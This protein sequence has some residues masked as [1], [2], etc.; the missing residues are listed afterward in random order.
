MLR[1]RQPPPVRAGWVWRAKGTGMKLTRWVMAALLLGATAGTSLATDDA[2]RTPAEVPPGAASG[3]LAAGGAAAPPAG[4]LGAAPPPSGEMAPMPEAPTAAAAEPAAE[5]AVPAAEAPPIA[6]AVPAVE[7]PPPIE[8]P[9]DPF[10][11]AIALHLIEDGP[12]IVAGVRLDGA[13]L[14]DLYVPEGFA[15]LWIG[16]DGPPPRIAVLRQVLA[17]AAEEGLDPADYYPRPI[18]DS[19][20]RDDM[21]ARAAAELLLS[22][23]VM[24]YGAELQAGRLTP[25]RLSRTFDITPKAVDRPAIARAAAAAADLPL[26]L[27]SL[28]PVRPGQEELRQALAAQRAVVAAGGWPTVPDGPTFRPGERSARV[29]ALRA[30]LAVTGDFTGNAADRSPVYDRAT[31]AAVERFQERHGLRADGVIGRDTVAALNV[32]AAT[33]LGQLLANLERWRWLPEEFG[34]RHIIVNVPDFALDVVERG[35]VVR[36]MDV[37][38]GRPDRETPL[39]S[40]ALTWLEFNPT[41]TVP[42]TIAYHDWLPRL[43]RDS[44][45]AAR[46]NMR[47]FSGRGAGAVELS[48]HRIDWDSVGGGIRRLML[49]Q[50]P[51]PGN[52]LG[53]VKFMMANNFSVYLHDTPSRH[54]F[55][56]DRRALSSGCVRVQDPIW[57]ADYLLQGNERWAAERER[58]LE[59]WRTTRVTLAEP[60]PLHIVYRTAWVDAQGRVNYREDVYGLD[61]VV[62][63]ALGERRPRQG[64]RTARA[65]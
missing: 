38:V 57:L 35:Q 17:A 39:F 53:K 13:A 59:G 61:E 49:R 14:R 47:V 45:A 65:D 25:R 37:I 19:L 55:A 8:L 20:S 12:V 51:G 7:A 11:R 41:W 29:P 3:A 44:G 31:A 64:S 28:A 9:S 16:P 27:R 60:V 40:S 22:A 4:A 21:E 33:R 62:L 52:A 10:R 23:A 26:A 30:R 63:D 5:A 54:L 48:A 36:H 24:R 43:R 50:E 32:D 18:A 6:E 1:W 2:A 34:E 42:A 56:R 58:I 46:A 15:P